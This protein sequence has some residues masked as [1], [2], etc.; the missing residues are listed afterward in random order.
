MGILYI[1]QSETSDRYYQEGTKGAPLALV[2]R[3]PR[4]SH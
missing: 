3:E 2:E 4:A 1:L